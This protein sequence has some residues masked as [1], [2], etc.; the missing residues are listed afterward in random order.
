MFFVTR[1]FDPQINGFPKR[2][3]EHVCVK[4][5]DANP[6]SIYGISCRKTD[7][8]TDKRIKPLPRRLPSYPT[9][10]GPKP[11]GAPKQ[12]LQTF[13]ASIYCWRQNKV[14]HPTI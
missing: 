13:K 1:D 3:V 2:I 5:G 4:F 14:P 9:G 11:R 8:Q 6:A 10:P 7:R 12:P